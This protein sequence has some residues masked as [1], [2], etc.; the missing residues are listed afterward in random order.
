MKILIAEDD[1]SFRR[2]MEKKL[3]AWGFEAVIAEDGNEALQILQSDDSPRLALLDWIMPGLEGV[4]VCRIVREKKEEA[5]KYIIMLTSQRRDSDIIT[6]MEAGADDYIMKPFKH[7]EL[8]L[9]LRAGRRII[10]LQNEL[11]AAR[12]MFRTKA[13]HDALTGL[14]N[15][16][17]IVE[18]LSHELARAKREKNSVGVIMADIDFFK[19]INDTH[20]HLAGDMVLR[21]TAGKMLSMMRA[22][23]FIGCYG[24]EEFLVI[25]PE[26]SLEYA[27]AFAERLRL[28]VSSDSIDTPEGMIS[29]TLSFGVAASSND[30]LKDAYSLINAADKALYRAKENGRNCVE[31]APADGAMA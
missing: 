19:K 14:W 11:L 4:E 27:S 28:S 10:E 30:R 20:G 22:Y 26:C 7:N 15:H 5:Y 24:G 6:G 23:D 2:F 8:R 21:L 25:L 1:L 12:D 3:T 16:G 17:E 29:I 18:I 31:V 9:R 13:S